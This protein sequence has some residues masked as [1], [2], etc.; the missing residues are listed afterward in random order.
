MNVRFEKELKRKN[1]KVSLEEEIKK[2]LQQTYSADRLI[3]GD[4][5]L[6]MSSKE[7]CVQSYKELQK[8]IDSD[9]RNVLYN[10]AKQ[11][12]VL[13]Y[14]KANLDKGISFLKC[15]EE[16]EISFSLSHC[17]FFIS[18]YELSVKHPMILQCS[19]EF[20]FVKANMKTI[21]NF[22]EKNTQGFFSLSDTDIYGNS[23]V[24]Q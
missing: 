11:G 20:G 24:Y 2:K 23:S 6:K 10:S 12:Q 18:L 8:L 7:E 19:V 3:T 21:R 16:K 15:I 14:L 4:Y 22:L 17:N 5:E 1:R 13:Q 9:K